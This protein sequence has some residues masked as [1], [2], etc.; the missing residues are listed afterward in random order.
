VTLEGLSVPGIDAGYASAT[1][2]SRGLS[3]SRTASGVSG[4]TRSEYGHPAFLEDQ[5]DVPVVVLGLV[6]ERLG[7]A[8]P[9]CVKK[10]TWVLGQCGC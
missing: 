2:M 9:S 3:G 5:L 7:I 10:D 1:V 8:D 6:A 4:R